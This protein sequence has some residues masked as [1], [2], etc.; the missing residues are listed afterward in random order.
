MSPDQAVFTSALVTA[1]STVA[2]SIAPKQ[3]GGEGEPPSVRMLIAT[4]LTFTGLSILSGIAPKLSTP[5]SACIAITALT[6]YGLPVLDATFTDKPKTAAAVART[7][8][9]LEARLDD[10]MASPGAYVII[11]RK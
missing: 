2:A 3:Y 9:N 7:N 10:V 1:G 5:L 8:P 6:Y 11:N 4:G